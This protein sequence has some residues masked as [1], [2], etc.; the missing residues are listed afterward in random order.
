M[1]YG[2]IC[3]A[4]VRKLH[5]S[6]MRVYDEDITA[7]H[8]ERG[9]LVHVTVDP[10]T[11][12][13]HT[14]GMQE[15]NTVLVDCAWLGGENPTREEM[16]EAQARMAAALRPAIPVGKRRLKLEDESF[17]TL[18]GV[19]HYAFCLRY[20]NAVGQGMPAETMQKLTIK[21]KEE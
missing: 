21:T 6:G 2:D 18:D 9:P 20:F 5:Q 19:A 13:L 4:I 10:V 14:A 12:E 3:R 7:T 16:R 1:T 8:L 17:R 11:T 15:Y